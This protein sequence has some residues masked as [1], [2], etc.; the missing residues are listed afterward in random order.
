VAFA[1]EAAARWEPRAAWR[2]LS[3]RPL[4]R[5]LSAAWPLAGAHPADRRFA[6]LAAGVLAPDAPPAGPAARPWSVVYTPPDHH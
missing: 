6:D 5:R 2:P 4:V 3:G 1:P